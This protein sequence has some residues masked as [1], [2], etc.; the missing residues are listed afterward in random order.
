MPIDI[1]LLILRIAILVALYAFLGAMFVMLARDTSVV[2]RQSLRWNTLTPGTLT[3]VESGE[4]K[5]EVGRRFELQRLTS[6][7]RSPTCTIT[8]PDSYAS[9]DHAHIVLRGERWW[10]EDQRSHN[11][12]AVNGMPV[13]ETIVLA[14]G[15]VIKIGSVSL[16]VELNN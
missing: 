12:T 3:V 15:D 4:T 7:G 14:S 13:S 9:A 16:L 5:L 11:G 1:V 2:A 6:L 8:V 10:L